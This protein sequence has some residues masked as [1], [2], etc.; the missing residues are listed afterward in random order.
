MGKMP[1]LRVNAKIIPFDQ[2]I[3]AIQ[4]ILEHAGMPEIVFLYNKHGV[5]DLADLKQQALVFAK[6]PDPIPSPTAGRNGYNNVSVLIVPNDSR[7]YTSLG[8][9]AV[10]ERKNRINMRARRDGGGIF[11]NTRRSK[12]AKAQ[13]QGGNSG[14]QPF[15]RS[16]QRVR[17]R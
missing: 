3:V 15:S 9:I 12:C 6:E 10:I 2:T 13:E 7:M 8:G 5:L 4:L 1:Y 11:F 14:K 17:H 16:I